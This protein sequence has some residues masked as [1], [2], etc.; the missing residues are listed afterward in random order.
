MRS[1]PGQGAD[2][3]CVGEGQG[4]QCLGV[5]APTPVCQL[6]SN[7]PPPTT[8]TMCMRVA[9]PHKLAGY[10][11]LPHLHSQADPQVRH[12]VLTR[13]LCCQDLALNTT[14]AKATRHQHTIS[15]TQLSQRRRQQQQQRRSAAVDPTAAHDAAAAAAAVH[16]TKQKHRPSRP[17]RRDSYLLPA[18]LILLWLLLLCVWL[19]VLRLH[20][21]QL[22][23]QPRRHAGVLRQDTY[24]H[25]TFSLSP[26]LHALLVFVPPCGTTH[27]EHTYRN[28][29]LLPVQTPSYTGRVTA[30]NVLVKQTRCTG[31]TQECGTQAAASPAA[32]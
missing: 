31:Q 18:L 30:R 25:M 23:L 27:T 1:R 29:I 20:P 24:T 22:Q 19:Q 10:L 32:P 28:L 26:C 4:V 11:T 7:I 6:R 14:V 8:R 9:V 3:Q 2:R 15:S 5:F 13:I 16:C 12:L 17:S 21:R